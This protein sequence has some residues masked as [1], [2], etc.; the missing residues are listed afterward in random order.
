MPRKNLRTI[1]LPESDATDRYANA[2]AVRD[3]HE[4]FE[5]KTKRS[6]SALAQKLDPYPQH[7]ARK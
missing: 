3:G 4:P 1:A 7:M 6:P 2:E 5:E